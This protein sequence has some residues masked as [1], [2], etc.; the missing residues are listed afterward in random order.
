MTSR[1]LLLA[2]IEFLRQSLADYE[3]P[4]PN[5]AF[6]DVKIFLHN[7]PEDLSA[8]TWPFVICRW[9]KGEIASR[10]DQ[11]TILKD[12]VV[13]YCGVYS[14]KNPTQAGL[15]CADLLDVLRRALWKTRILDN[16][17]ELLEPIVAQMAQPEQQI[18]QY[19]YLT[20]ETVWEYI[21]PPRSLYEAGISQLK[22]RQITSASYSAPEIERA[23]GE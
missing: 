21:W 20:L 18:H 4:A 13:L 14:P 10:P 7:L 8:E 3:F 12:T 16:R 17:F 6:R 9:Q 2:I 23:Q 5:G 11:A 1:S 15:L 22:N 19:H